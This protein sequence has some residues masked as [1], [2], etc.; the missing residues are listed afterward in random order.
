MNPNIKNR[1]QQVMNKDVPTQLLVLVISMQYY[2]ENGVD[3]EPIRCQDS[4]YR[5]SVNTIR[6][7]TGCHFT[8]L[9]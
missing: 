4:K 7:V 5:L 9:K 3:L 1:Q 8:E 2:E 6:V